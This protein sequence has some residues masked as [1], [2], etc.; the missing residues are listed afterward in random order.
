MS[1]FGET[2]VLQTTLASMFPISYEVMRTHLAPRTPQPNSPLAPEKVRPLVLTPF[3]LSYTGLLKIADLN[4]ELLFLARAISAPT[5]TVSGG[6]GLVGGETLLIDITFNDV[7]I[8]DVT[9]PLV[10]QGLNL[11]G[12]LTFSG[13]ITTIG[14]I[15]IGYNTI[16][17]SLIFAPEVT[18]ASLEL[19]SCNVLR[20]ITLPPA[21]SLVSLLVS[22][23]YPQ[24]S[25]AILGDKKMYPALTSLMYLNSVDGQEAR[26]IPPTTKGF[27]AFS[28]SGLTA[29]S[30]PFVITLA[31]PDPWNYDIEALFPNLITLYMIGS[32]KE[33]TFQIPAT[34]KSRYSMLVVIGANQLST[35][36]LSVRANSLVQGFRIVGCPQLTG[37]LLR[38]GAQ[39]TEPLREYRT[40]VIERCGLIYLRGTRGLIRPPVTLRL[41]DH[42]SP[43]LQTSTVKS[44]LIEY[45]LEAL[46]YIGSVPATATDYLPNVIVF[47]AEI[48]PT[49]IQ[50]PVMQTV[51]YSFNRAAAVAATGN[52]TTS[53][54][55]YSGGANPVV[56][57]NTQGSTLTGASI[58]VSPFGIRYTLRISSSK[59]GGTA[60]P[61]IGNTIEQ[62]PVEGSIKGSIIGRGTPAE[63][64]KHLKIAIIVIS[65]IAVVILMIGIITYL[66]L[67]AR[68]S[69]LLVGSTK[70]PPGPHLK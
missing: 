69:K 26:D 42:T 18:V 7:V 36:D 1:Q 33:G 10:V 50:Y 13:G 70:L 52:L 23:H 14:I 46:P 8:D 64:K 27:G 25:L 4:T 47:L 19:Y 44:R 32:S 59:L 43:S 56:P 39:D 22:G 16:N 12:S 15:H 30:Y 31:V 17:N 9:I 49:L 62:P 51:E 11:S 60:S 38:P 41:G 2:T 57:T 3:S 24:I 34:P 35:L 20:S 45:V 48:L 63:N 67:R 58:T 53:Y 55:Q 6:I 54:T 29:S 61:S 65:V 21:A 40:M 66:V 68:A 5:Q 28:L 37:V